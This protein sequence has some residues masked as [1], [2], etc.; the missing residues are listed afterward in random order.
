[1]RALAERS[2]F[3]R[4]G[5]GDGQSHN[6]YVGAIG[7]LGIVSSFF[8]S[9]KV[10]HNLKSR[11]TV[12]RIELSYLMDG[13]SGR[14]SYLADFPD[15]GEV[16]LRGNL[17]HKGPRAENPNAI[18]FGAEGLKWPRNVLEMVHNTVVVG[19]PGGAFIS[20]AAGTES[21]QLT[22]NLFADSGDQR[23]TAG[24]FDAARARQSHNLIG[25]ADQVPGAGDILAPRFWPAPA[26]RRQLRRNTS[27][28]VGYRADAPRPLVARTMDDAP[29]FVGT[30]QS[31]P[32]GANA[33][34]CEQD[35]LGHAFACSRRPGSP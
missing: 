14:S 31:P 24:H 8:H 20:I 2:E 4:N 19:R 3:A 35:T 15:G 28:D 23:L 30:L 25:R 17:F 6:L 1:M 34:A 9:A 33:S 32:Q 22:A 13:A 16:L 18:A 5:Y 10:G 12:S 29:R 26:L 21:V 27:S 7:R 11:A